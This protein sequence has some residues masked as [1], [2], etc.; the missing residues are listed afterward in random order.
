MQYIILKSFFSAEKV[1]KRT[2]ISIELNPGDIG[3]GILSLI[4]RL[5]YANW[6]GS[7]PRAERRC[8]KSCVKVTPSMQ[9]L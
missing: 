2:L 3:V 7:T 5:I 6:Q 9:C 8:G 1:L 4:Y